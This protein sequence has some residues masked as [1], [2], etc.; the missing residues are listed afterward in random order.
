MTPPSSSKTRPLPPPPLP[1]IPPHDPIDAGLPVIFSF[2]LSILSCPPPSHS[3]IDPFEMSTITHGI[4]DDT[5]EGVAGNYRKYAIAED[6]QGLPKKAEHRASWCQDT[7]KG[8][9]AGIT[10]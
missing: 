1:C 8:S 10:L 5:Q 4:T 9:E 3:S 2:H 6:R 7:H